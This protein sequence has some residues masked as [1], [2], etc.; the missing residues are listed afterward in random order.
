MIFFSKI[1]GKVCLNFRGYDTSCHFYLS[2][3]LLRVFESLNFGFNYFDVAETWVDLA[4]QMSN[5]MIQEVPVEIS[6]DILL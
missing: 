1:S 2:H 6:E 5:H 4:Q 3:D